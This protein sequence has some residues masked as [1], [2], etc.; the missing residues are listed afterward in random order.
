MKS[1]VQY[2]EC[3]QNEVDYVSNNLRQQ[4]H[5]SNDVQVDVTISPNIP[6]GSVRTPEGFHV[7][8]RR[9]PARIYLTSVA[10]AGLAPL[11]IVAPI[12]GKFVERIPAS[13]PPVRWSWTETPVRPSP[14]LVTRN[15]QWLAFAAHHHSQLEDAAPLQPADSPADSELPSEIA[16]PPRSIWSFGPFIMSVGILVS[17]LLKLFCAPYFAKCFTE[18]LRS[19]L[20][21]QLPEDT[22][23]RAATAAPTVVASPCP[24][25]SAPQLH[26]GS[27]SRPNSS[28]R[29]SPKWPCSLDLPDTTSRSTGGWPQNPQPAGPGSQAGSSEEGGRGSRRVTFAEAEQ[30]GPADQEPQHGAAG[31]VEPAFEGSGLHPALRRAAESNSTF[32]KA[33]RQEISRHSGE[34]ARAGAGGPA[35]EEEQATTLL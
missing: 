21:A 22:A 32:G 26:T 34:D 33:L 14:H 19:L 9:V 5:R 1:G 8:A 24:A 3:P 18:F 16:D 25:A 23:V 13:I 7:V 4:N 30:G 29:R 35:A 2:R 10:L 28:P 20:Q 12:C 27:S 6:P 15:Q 31:P 11:L 17:V